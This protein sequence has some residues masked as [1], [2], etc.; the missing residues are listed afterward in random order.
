[1]QGLVSASPSCGHL[2][3]ED[4]ISYK[5]DFQLEFNSA[6]KSI[7]SFSASHICSRIAEL[8][9]SINSEFSVPPYIINKLHWGL[10][11]VANMGCVL[12]PTGGNRRLCTTVSKSSWETTRRQAP[13]PQHLTPPRKL[14]PYHQNTISQ[15]RAI[16]GPCEQWRV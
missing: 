6:R 3:A 5:A 8:S 11:A 2:R 7:L 10:N 15:T 14:I 13:Q 4:Q 1:M 12:G 9:T 16:N